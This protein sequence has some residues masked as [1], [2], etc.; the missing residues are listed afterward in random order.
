MRRV[1][2][3]RRRNGTFGFEEWHWD[4]EDESWIPVGPQSDSFTDSL[5]RALFEAR[6]RVQWLE[7]ESAAA[8]PRVPHRST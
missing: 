8:D 2:I 6:G 3:F 4:A 1:H 7:E 5:E